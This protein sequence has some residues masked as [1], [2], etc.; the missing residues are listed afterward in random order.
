MKIFIFLISLLMMGESVAFSKKFFDSLNP[1]NLK[2]TLKKMS[3]QNLRYYSTKEDFGTAF[4]KKLRE[5]Y[6]DKKY[7]GNIKSI[8]DRKR[9]TLENL[10]WISSNIENL[11]SN[12][13]KKEIEYIQEELEKDLEPWKPFIEYDDDL[14]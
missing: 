9:K 12:E 13:V 8:V 1:L 6:D 11:S 4:Y 14:Y 7:K 5:L 3:V 2:K 10:E